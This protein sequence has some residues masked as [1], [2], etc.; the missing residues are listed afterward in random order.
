M[1][2][3]DTEVVRRLVT[4][5][6]DDGRAVYDPQAMV[7]VVRACKKPGVSVARMALQCG[8]NANLLRRWIT[9]SK[10]ADVKAG[11]ANMPTVATAG[12]DT[13]VP[14]RL[15]APG[16]VPVTAVALKLRLHARL[17]N[18]VEV[19][20]GDAGPGELLPFLDLLGRLPCSDSTI[21]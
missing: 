9:Q 4:G 3:I 14:L 12:T 2:E 7:E 19:D 5:R 6:K 13:F 21:R 18:G 16:A 17:L 8:I 10:G 1:S 15:A 11:W 20:L